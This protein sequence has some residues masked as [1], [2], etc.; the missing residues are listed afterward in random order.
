MYGGREQGKRGNENEKETE[1]GRIDRRER[2]R[3]EGSGAVPKLMSDAK[4]IP[5]VT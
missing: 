4:S 5:K 2:G 3:E 1:G